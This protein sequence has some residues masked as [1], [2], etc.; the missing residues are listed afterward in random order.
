MLMSHIFSYFEM[1]F[2]LYKRENC[3]WDVSLQLYLNNLGGERGGGGIS[4]II[5]KMAFVQFYL[6][7]VYA[8]VSHF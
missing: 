7:L 2:R 5:F 3:T 8:D 6:G 1:R 4:L